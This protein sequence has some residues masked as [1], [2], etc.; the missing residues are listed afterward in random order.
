MIKRSILIPALMATL[1]S[2]SQKSNLKF[3][4]GD[5]YHLPRKAEDIGFT[6]NEKFGMVNLSVNDDKLFINRFDIATL[7]K[8]SEEELK[9]NTSSRMNSET[10]VDF[11]SGFCYW[12]YSDWD[13]K[14][15]KKLLFYDKIDIAKGQMAEADHKI[16]ETTRIANKES[17]MFLTN[18]AKEQYHESF[19]Y[20]YNYDKTHTKLLISYRLIPESKRDKKNFDKIG[21][22]VLDQSMKSHRRSPKTKYGVQNSLER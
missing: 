4:L 15:D 21:L 18:Y 1:F 16:N 14:N 17:V 20:S 11:G 2:Y 10:L 22:I 9:M 3:K 5:E 6:G 7:N 13:K 19:K 12:I 8:I